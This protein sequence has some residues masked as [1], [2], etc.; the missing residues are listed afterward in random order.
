[1]SL[2]PGARLGPYEVIRLIGAGGMGEVYRAR[3]TRLD[4]TVAIKI[5]SDA[6]VANADR[7][8]RFEREARA[9]AALNHPHICALHD[10][11]E[12][13]GPGEG[14]PLLFL[15]M[16]YIEGRALAERLSS[17]PLPVADVIR[18]AIEL[19]DALDHAHRHG[20]VHRDVKPG[21]VMLTRAGAKLLDFGLAKSQFSP[22]LPALTTISPGAIPLTATGAMLGTFPYMAPEQLAGHD[23]DER[24]DIFALGA[25][26][27]EMTTG[28]RAFDGATAATVIGAVLHAD[29]PPVSSLQRAAP[30]ALDRIVSRCLAKDPENRWQSA[31]DLML[32]L[33]WIAGQ[34]QSPVSTRVRQHTSPLLIA[35]ALLLALLMTVAAGVVYWRPS[36][37]QDVPVRLTFTPPAGVTLADLATAGPVTISPD[38]RRLAF[39]ASTSDG[40]RRL[41]VRSLDSTNPTP[42]PGTDGAAYPFWSPDS[43]L[44][45]FFAGGNL[46]KIQAEG[47]PPQTLC[48]AIQPRGGTWSQD[49]VIVFSGNAGNQLYRTSEDGGVATPLTWR[50]ANSEKLWPSFLPDGRHVVYFARPVKPGIYLGSLDSEETSFVAPAFGGVAYVPGY[51]LLLQAG[52][53]GGTSQ[54]VSLIAQPFDADRLQFTGDGVSIADHIQYRTLWARGGFSV[55]TT[56]T[57]VTESDTLKTQMAW[58]DRQGR[59][60]ETV[61]GIVPSA[62]RRW[63]ELS[64]DDTQLATTDQDPI[65]GTTDVHIFNLTSATDSRLTSGPAL[66]SLSRWSSDSRHIVFMSARDDLPPNLFR[67]STAGIRRDERLTESKLVQHPNDWSRDGRFL[68]FAMLDPKTQWDVWRLPMSDSATAAGP[69]QPLLRGPLAECNAQLSPDGRWIV[70][71]SDESGD[72]EI[73]LRELGAPTDRPG[74]QISSDGGVWPVWR[75]DGREL[76]Y[77]AA[78]GT[79]M[80]VAITHG[81]EIEAGAPQSLFK[82]DVVELWNVIRNYTVARDGQRFLI[83]TRVEEASDPPTIVTLNWPATVRR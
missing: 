65:V 27:H 3:D 4:R 31:R 12:G 68:L 75:H 63:P 66:D 2:A 44:I 43:R 26:I 23:V 30:A 18:Y 51:L 33:R 22:G 11:G 41:W 50:E 14:E 62:S 71:Q 1:M 54:T 36:P 61:R 32:D 28:R 34:P 80:A 42:L 83:N 55:S 47:G 9:V 8:A 15:V 17:G 5:V 77:I 35:A 24:S 69:P 70:Y 37:G 73:Y 21:N 59:R 20:L 29:P 19:A 60:L 76:F 78:D 79:L 39:V 81:R 56:G 74:K 53:P 48:P 10:V 6:F 57:L 13:R 58:F 64:P 16:E 38:G 67:T 40:K 45:G 72:W 46:K 82:T 7:R 49:G 52:S 25:I